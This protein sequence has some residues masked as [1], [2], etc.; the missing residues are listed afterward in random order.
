MIPH[1]QLPNPLH[2]LFAKHPPQDKGRKHEHYTNGEQVV[3]IVT[4]QQGQGRG[5]GVVDWIGQV[6]EGLL[7]HVP[8]LGE[9]QDHHC[10][11]AGAAGWQDGG[12]QYFCQPAG[13]QP[14][15]LQ[16]NI[17]DLPHGMAQQESPHR[18]KQQGDDQRGLGIV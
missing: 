12:A 8:D 5:Q 4:G 11:D 9:G 18:R 16:V 3:Q 17:W 13:L 7:H 2:H 6:E 10:Q 14:D 1:L 15:R